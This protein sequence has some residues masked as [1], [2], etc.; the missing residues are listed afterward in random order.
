MNVSHRKLAGAVELVIATNAVVLGGIGA[1]FG[2][3][4]VYENLCVAFWPTTEATLSLGPIDSPKFRYNSVGL[5]EGVEFEGEEASFRPYASHLTEMEAWGR[6]LNLLQMM[7]P[8]S[9]N[10]EYTVGGQQYESSSAYGQNRPLSH[11]R[12]SGESRRFPQEE[13]LWLEQL[14]HGHIETYYNPRN[15]R[16]SSLWVPLLASDLFIPV[17]SLAF[18]FFGS[19]LLI[20]MVRPKAALIGLATSSFLCV[21]LVPL[22]RS[23]ADRAGFFTF[24]G[25]LLVW[26]VAMTMGC[27]IAVRL[28]GFSEETILVPSLAVPRQDDRI[29]CHCP[30]CGE[31]LRPLKRFADTEGK[32][33]KCYKVYRIPPLD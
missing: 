18:C 29:E 10:Y 3:A 8:M 23:M 12:G 16:E 2:A 20:P 24:W 7:A 6:C 28:A 5:V 21:P 31:L 27:A 15:P 17:L 1:A 32:C 4:I 33:S 9:P 25:L 11:P 13:K 30:H 26:L 22:W 19:G 14:R